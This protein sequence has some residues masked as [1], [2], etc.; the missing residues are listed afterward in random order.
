MKGKIFYL[1]CFF[2]FYCT[3]PVYAETMD[4][5]G[6]FETTTKGKATKSAKKKV[7]KVNAYTVETIAKELSKWSGLNFAINDFT[8]KGKEIFIDWSPSASFFSSKMPTIPKKTFRFKNI[9]TLAWFM[10]DSLYISL[11]EN[12]D[13][14]SIVYTMDGGKKLVIDNLSPINEFPLNQ[15]YKGS[16]AYFPKNNKSINSKENVQTKNSNMM[17]DEQIFARTKGRWRLQGKDS[18]VSLIIMD[19]RGGFTS[20]SMVGTLKNKGYLEYNQ[21][22]EQGRFE[23]FGLD[24]NFI[25]SFYFEDDEQFQFDEGQHIYAK[26]SDLNN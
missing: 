5:Y 23:M 26:E 19:G 20:Y 21:D 10:L 16:K 13:L 17:A 7:V 18:A 1:F 2:I 15:A 11:L 8:L 14:T 6:V 9:N 25:A 4:L 12:F 24:K 22:E 3:L